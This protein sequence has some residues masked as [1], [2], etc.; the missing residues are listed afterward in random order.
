MSEIDPIYPIDSIDPIALVKSLRSEGIPLDVVIDHLVIHIH[1][2]EDQIKTKD[3]FIHKLC[4]RIPVVDEMDLDGDVI[5]YDYDYPEPVWGEQANEIDRDFPIRHIENPAF[6]P[7][8]A[9]QLNL[10]RQYRDN[11]VGVFHYE[12]LG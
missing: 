9:E 5:M 12:G 3:M 4:N 11:E 1:T 8:E 10:A 6:D 2:L 7:Q